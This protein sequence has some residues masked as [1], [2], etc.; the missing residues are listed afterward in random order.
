MDQSSAQPADR[1][2]QN[3]DRIRIQQG[4]RA[5]ANLLGRSATIVELFRVPLDSCLARIDGDADRDR[6]WFFYRDEFVISSA[7]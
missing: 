6:L 7:A 3:G 5:I 1:D 4:R 2:P